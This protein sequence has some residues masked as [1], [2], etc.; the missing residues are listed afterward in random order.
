M[1]VCFACFAWFVLSF[2]FSF[3]VCFLLCIYTKIIFF[4]IVI[5]LFYFLIFQVL[6]WYTYALSI[7]YF[8]VGRK[9]NELTSGDSDSGAIPPLPHFSKGK[10]PSSLICSWYWSRCSD[11]FSP[12]RY[13]IINSRRKNRNSKKKNLIWK[14]S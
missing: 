4:V 11:I 8:P 14:I 2:C 12:L 5:L 9:K 10:D 13:K 1:S 7:P 3:F 6:L